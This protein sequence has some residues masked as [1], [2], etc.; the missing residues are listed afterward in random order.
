MMKQRFISAF[1]CLLSCLSCFE[2][3]TSAAED[4]VYHWY[5]V[6][7]SENKQPIADSNMRWI[8]NYGGYYI[9]HAH[10]NDC[11]EKVVYLTFD[12]GYENGNVERILDVMKE[13]E[14]TGAFFVLGHLISKNPELICRME[15]EGHLVCNHT[16]RHKDMTSV[17]DKNAFEKELLELEIMY[18]KVTGKEMAKY[19]RPPEGTFDKRSLQFASELGY[20][21]VFWSLAYADWDN[22]R[23]P[24][25]QKS[26]E[27]L[28]RYMHNGAVI[29]L[30]PTSKTNALI[31]KDLIGTLKLQGFRFGSLNE[32]CPVEKQ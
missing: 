31:L 26:K 9:D 19:Y 10:G 20:K 1:L 16:V 15:K 17:D 32:L 25:P 8:E 11:E 21:T 13:E 5:C 22:D 24:D 27:L 28:L 14:V 2:F 4:T 12:A 29:L 6:R 7:N 18:Q 30:H 3:V 23:Q